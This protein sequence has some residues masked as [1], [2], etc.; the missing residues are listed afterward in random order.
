MDIFEE[1]INFG[2]LLDKAKELHIKSKT[3]DCNGVDPVNWIYNQDKLRKSWEIFNKKAENM[4]PFKDAFINN[5]WYKYMQFMY[6]SFPAG[7]GD[8]IQ[9]QIKIENGHKLTNYE[10]TKQWRK[11]N[12]DKYREQNKRKYIARK[13]RMQQQ[14]PQQK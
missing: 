5:D 7:Y 8:L 6:D 13:E 9:Q 4:G 1:K 12:P 10:K 2:E 3:F 11:N 14:E